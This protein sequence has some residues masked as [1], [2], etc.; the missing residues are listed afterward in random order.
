MPAMK[1]KISRT[2]FSLD[3]QIVSLRYFQD[4]IVINLKPKVAGLI[5]WKVCS[6]RDFFSHNRY[7]FFILDEYS[8][9]EEIYSIKL[10]IGKT[11][12]PVHHHA[13]TILSFVFI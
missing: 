12:H 6:S 10:F 13:I 1:I 3:F 5:L 9:F 11:C 8:D 2:F 4:N 7:R